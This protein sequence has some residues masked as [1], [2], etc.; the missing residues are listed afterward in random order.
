MKPPPPSP[1]VQS[2]TTAIA[3]P[4]SPVRLNRASI[5][6]LDT[7]AGG[8]VRLRA[9]GAARPP[10]RAPDSSRVPFGPSPAQQRLCAEAPSTDIERRAAADRGCR[11]DGSAF[12]VEIS[13]SAMN[14]PARFALRHLGFAQLPLAA[15]QTIGTNV[16]DPCGTKTLPAGMTS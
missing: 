5:V 8:D 7:A 3:A 11:K 9:S 10:S 6:C 2:P 1:S 16:H 12:P 15:V 13:Q 4:S 14:L